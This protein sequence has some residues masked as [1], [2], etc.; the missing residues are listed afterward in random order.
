MFTHPKLFNSAINALAYRRIITLKPSQLEPTNMLK[1]IVFTTAILLPSMHAIAAPPHMDKL[2]MNP[3]KDE[4][5]LGCTL[6]KHCVE[7]TPSQAGCD[8]QTCAMADGTALS[9]KLS[10]DRHH[11]AY[12]SYALAGLSSA[13]EDASLELWPKI[14]RFDGGILAGVLTQVRTMYSGGGAGSTTL[15]LIAF[16][17]DQP[18]FEVLSVPE[19]AEVMIRACFSEYDMKQRAGACHDEYR[20]DTHITLTGASTAGMPVLRYRSQATSFPGPV[21]RSKDSLAERPLR[22]RD[23]VTITDSQCSYQRLYRFKPKV[24]SYAPTTPPPDCSNYTSP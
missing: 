21:S 15:H 14:I 9:L 11:L 3:S 8:R 2:V 4:S 5:T 24:R 1:S 19:H 7:I 18:P 12:P 20:F 17:P 16:L 22:K 13:D 6:D 10:S 23:L